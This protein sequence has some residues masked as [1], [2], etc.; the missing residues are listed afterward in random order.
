MHSSSACTVPQSSE[1]PV[2]LSIE[3]LDRVALDLFDAGAFNPAKDVFRL[4]LLY[5]PS[6]AATWYWL[7]RCHQELGEEDKA[8]RLFELAYDAGLS[9]LFLP[10]ARGAALG[11]TPAQHRR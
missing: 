8:M 4:L 6:Q 3:A 2:R 1:K 7:A 10:L 5:R 11:H 9:P